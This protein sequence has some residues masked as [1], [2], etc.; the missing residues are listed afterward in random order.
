MKNNFVEQIMVEKQMMIPNKSDK[1]YAN[2]PSEIDGLSD[3]G[4]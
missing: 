2:N 3:E 4:N 1:A